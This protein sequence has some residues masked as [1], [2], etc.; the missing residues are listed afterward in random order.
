ML[1]YSLIIVPDTPSYLPNAPSGGTYN[2]NVSTYTLEYSREDTGLFLESMYNVTTRGISNATSPRDEQWGACLACAVVERRRQYQNISRSG[3]CESCFDR[4]CW[5][6]ADTSG[7][8]ANAAQNPNEVYT[9]DANSLMGDNKVKIV[10][11]VA[12]FA[13]SALWTM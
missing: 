10:L 13:A 3:I 12:A 6:A 4:Y 7:M 9:D 11:G 2:T 8:G 1:Q 5:D